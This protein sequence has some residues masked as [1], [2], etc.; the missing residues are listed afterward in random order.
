[1]VGMI[2][3]GWIRNAFLIGVMVAWQATNNKKYLEAAPKWAVQNRWRPGL[4]SRLADD[5]CAGQGYTE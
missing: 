5:H 2:L 3:L 1:M 4:Q